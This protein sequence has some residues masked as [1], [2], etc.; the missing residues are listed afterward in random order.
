MKPETDLAAVLGSALPASVTAL[1][2]EVRARLAVQ[3]VAAK[4][5]QDADMAASI[6]VAIAG[7]PFAVR[8]IVKKALLG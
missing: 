3:V 1:P 6:E 2:E 8:G 7:V 4:K 5:Q